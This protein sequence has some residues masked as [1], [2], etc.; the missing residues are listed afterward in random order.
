MR[1]K[2]NDLS[3]EVASHVRA[4]LARQ[5]ISGSGLAKALG[6]PQSNLQRRLIGKIPF[7]F[8]ELDAIARLI[9]VP[10]SDFWPLDRAS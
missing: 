3:R 8:D 9:G 7:T 10:L 2:T 6:K 4:E 5:Q 1:M